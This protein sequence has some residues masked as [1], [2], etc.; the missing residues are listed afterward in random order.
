VLARLARER[1]ALTYA[2]GDAA[3]KGGIELETV[4]KRLVER[5]AA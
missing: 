5:A 3:G 4:L 2:C 1:G